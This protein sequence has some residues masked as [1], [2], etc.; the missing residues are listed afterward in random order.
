MTLTVEDLAFSYGR[1]SRS[2]S[3][4]SFSVSGGEV[5]CLI[6]PNGAGKT[7]LLRSLIGALTPSGGRVTLDGTPVAALP[8]R[9]LAQRLAYV[10][11]A[12]T[13]AFGHTVREIV[14]MG[15]TAHLGRL[16]VPGKADRRCADQAL[17]RVGLSHLAGRNFAAISGGERQLCLIAR[18]L[19]QEAQLIILD[20][21]AAS[22]DFGNQIR[23][24]QIILGLRSEGFGLLMC[25]HHPDHALQ[26]GTSFLALQDGL[27]HAAGPVSDLTRP[28]YLSTLYGR[29]VR[30]IRAAD[31]ALACVPQ[32]TQH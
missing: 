30:V 28:G 24:L 6:G 4:I 19:A 25:T 18:A 13:P 3:G 8:P 23:L 26:V 15:R 5:L 21:P 20:E 22:L 16:E 7:T 2:I 32:L 31:G 1:G 27:T 11:Q 29:D 9:N 14:L 12:T 10:P 17:E